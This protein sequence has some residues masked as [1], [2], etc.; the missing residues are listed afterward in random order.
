MQNEVS[1]SAADR[2]ESV[3]FQKHHVFASQPARLRLAREAALSGAE[4]I[5]HQIER[6]QE[7]RWEVGLISRAY[8]IGEGE[9]ARYIQVIP[10]ALFSEVPQVL[11]PAAI[12]RVQV[13]LASFCSE[14]L[15]VPRL[16]SLAATG[17]LH[18]HIQAATEL[19]LEENAHVLNLIAYISLPLFED[20]ESE[21]FQRL[22]GDAAGHPE[23]QGP[24]FPRFFFT[25]LKAISCAVYLLVE[26]DEE[27]T[28]Q[29][30][31]E[32]VWGPDLSR[33]AAM[34]AHVWVLHR[35]SGQAVGHQPAINDALPAQHTY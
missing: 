34:V 16:K 6:N 35:L 10:N 30:V 1:R 11:L 29:D 14:L 33:F 13:S 21:A 31:E 18:S 20:F 28:P 23:S 27:I 3:W 12:Y 4:R 17:R 26:H 9:Q 8:F 32:M 24:D 19:I 22:R 15:Q 7:R 5:V 2:K 25:K